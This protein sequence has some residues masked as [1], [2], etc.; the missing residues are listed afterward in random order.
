MRN[1]I[2]R[3]RRVIV[4]VIV[5]V[6]LQQ[7]RMIEKLMSY[8]KRYLCVPNHYSILLMYIIAH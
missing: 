5:I 7:V 1:M 6:I 4:I 2:I 3:M 8:Y